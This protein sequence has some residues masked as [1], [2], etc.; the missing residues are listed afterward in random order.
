VI[1]FYCIAGLVLAAAWMS[2]VVDAAVGM[3]SIPD[4]S[5][6]AFDRTDVPQSRVSVIVPARNEEAHIEQ[7]LTR[8]LNQDY[9][10]YEVIAI[11]D[12]STDDTGGVIDRVAT[13]LAATGRL[14]PIHISE[15]PLDWMGKAHAMWVAA[16]QATGEWLLFTDADIGFSSDCL[17]RAM[18]YAQQSKADHVVLFPTL[19]MH[20]V[21]ERMMLAFFQILFVFG[22]RPWKVADPRTKD[23]MG[24][25]AFNLIRRK[26]YETIGTHREL[27]FEV[28]DDMKLGK[29]VKEHGFAQRSILGKGLITLRWATNAM[30]VVRNLTKNFFALMHFRWPRALGACLLLGFLNWMPFLGIW[31]APGWCRLAYAL[32]LLS[33]LL[34]YVG[35]WQYANI[36]PLYFFLH[37][38]ATL[39]LIYT[40]MRSTFL[41]LWRGGVVWRGTFYPLAALRRGMV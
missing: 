41:T 32:A 20:S 6:P 23:H 29:L 35:I 11:N 5:G 15:L 30:G 18:A 17:R 27:R 39:L 33:M 14:M 9:A 40:M 26:V 36:S 34:I 8:L 37:P 2:R 16:Q 25:G 3:P 24:I 13:S 7:T 10:N 38:I 4:I 28:L 22:H 31:L 1:Y 21:G 19:Q 12:R